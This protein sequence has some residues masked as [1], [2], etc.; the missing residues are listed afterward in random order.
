MSENS[1]TAYNGV[2]IN[3]LDDEEMVDP[4][5][6]SMEGSCFPPEKRIGTEEVEWQSTSGE[7]V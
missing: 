2:T 5:V 4:R 6:E 7:A 3:L 1:L